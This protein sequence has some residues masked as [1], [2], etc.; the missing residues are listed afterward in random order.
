[1]RSSPTTALPGSRR[2]W[3]YDAAGVLGNRLPWLLLCAA[4]GQPGVNALRPPTNRQWACA[5]IELGGP[6]RKR[7][8]R[9]PFT[10]LAT[11][12]GGGCLG[13]R[14]RGI[15]ALP[16]RVNPTDRQTLLRGPRDCQGHIFI[17]SGL[18]I[19]IY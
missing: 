1:P 10:R 2:R 18:N 4:V 9:M 11:A 6:R 16:V 3:R 7:N 8:R 14:F 19:F 12:P 17:S 15:I 13:T 5:R